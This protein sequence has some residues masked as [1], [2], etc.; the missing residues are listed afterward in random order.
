MGRMVDKAVKETNPTNEG[1]KENVKM[2]NNV[3]VN[4]KKNEVMQLQSCQ[5]DK[6]RKATSNGSEQSKTINWIN[7]MLERSQS[8]L[9]SYKSYS[10]FKDGKAIKSLLA[11]QA[12]HY[13]DWFYHDGKP[14]SDIEMFLSGLEYDFDISAL[15]RGRK[16]DMI[17]FVNWIKEDVEKQ[18]RNRK[19]D[20]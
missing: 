7:K 18:V 16:Q 11:L 8:L 6:D 5:V 9:P 17:K 10:E 3:E 13:P 20:Y 4:E 1:V 12:G 15:K 19:F 2:E 14:W